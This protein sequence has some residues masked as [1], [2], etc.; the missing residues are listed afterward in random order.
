M[1]SFKEYTIKSDVATYHIKLVNG[2]VTKVSHPLGIL[3]GQ[4]IDKVVAYVEA[5]GWTLTL[6]REN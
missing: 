4:R 2:H 6:I 1:D 5:R 3:R